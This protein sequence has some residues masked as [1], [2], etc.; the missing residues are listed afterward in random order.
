LQVE[1][2]VVRAYQSVLAPG[3][4]LLL[5]GIGVLE[6]GDGTSLAAEQTVKVGTDLV[7]FTLLEGVA[8]SASGLE[9]V[10]T[11]LGVAC[12]RGIVS[13]VLVSVCS[14]EMILQVHALQS[15]E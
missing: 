15:C 9:E 14:Q 10:G 8:L 1:K 5:V 12:G 6:A 11:L 7:A 2:G 13:G 3:N 4:G